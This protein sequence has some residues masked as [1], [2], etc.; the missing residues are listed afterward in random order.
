MNVSTVNHVMAEH[1]GVQLLETMKKKIANTHRHNLATGRR[2]S[3]NNWNATTRWWVQ[4]GPVLDKCIFSE[5]TAVAKYAT[6]EFESRQS[7][8]LH[9]KLKLELV[10]RVLAQY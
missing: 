2:F 3:Q 7:S 4:A 9:A 1:F 10:T 5:F 6:S 8:S